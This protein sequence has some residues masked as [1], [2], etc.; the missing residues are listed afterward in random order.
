MNAN[1]FCVIGLLVLASALCG[2][3][4]MKQ[5]DSTKLATTAANSDNID[6]AYVARVDRQAMERGI[7]VRWVHPPQAPQVSAH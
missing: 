7:E 3:A 6:L 5:G 4:S 2:C 1:V